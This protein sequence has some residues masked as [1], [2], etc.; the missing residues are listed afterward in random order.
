EVEVFTLSTRV[1]KSVSNIPPAF[2]TYDLTFCHVFVDGFIYWHAFDNSKWANGIRSNLIISFDLTSDE[3]G[4]VC[5]PG[6]LMYN[7]FMIS[8]V[9]E[10]LGLFEY[11]N[12]GETRFFDV[13]IMKEG[14]TKSFAKMLSIKAPD[15]W[16]CYRVLELR[17][18]GEAIIEN[19]N[20]TNSSVLEVYEPSSGR[21]SS[22]GVNGTFYTFSVNS[23]IETLL[24]L[25]QP[26]SVIH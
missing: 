10:S 12:E 19:I 20:D 21:I 6:R 26:N 1:W 14:V 16:V 2:Q 22:V 5:L 8:K 11:Y 7:K 23:Y 15:S 9:Y 4:E 13:W 24:L 18:N 3:F 25:D 17:Q